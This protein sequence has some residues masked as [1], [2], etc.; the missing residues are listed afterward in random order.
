MQGIPGR[1]G[2]P[3][4]RGKTG[5]DGREGPPGERGCPGERGEKGDKGDRGERGYNG[6]R[7][8]RG[9]RGVVSND[10]SFYRLI[11]SDSSDVPMTYFPMRWYATNDLKE[12]TSVTIQ[13]IDDTSVL[14][15]ST[16]SVVSKMFVITGDRSFEG[17]SSIIVPG[18]PL[19]FEFNVRWN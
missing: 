3:G 17:S 13:Y 8:E 4:E 1:E 18:K 14:V 7:G 6:E 19:Q 15:F 2:P 11:I 16:T 9:E 5:K 10:F 12:I